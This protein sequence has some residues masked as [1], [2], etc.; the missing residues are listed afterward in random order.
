[1]FVAESKLSPVYTH[2][3]IA[4]CLL[5][6]QTKICSSSALREP[7]LFTILY[8]LIFKSNLIQI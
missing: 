5:A 6:I 3:W 8:T 4:Y 1:M 2:R 7:C